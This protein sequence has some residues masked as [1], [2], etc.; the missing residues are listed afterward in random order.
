MTVLGY[1]A[2]F[3]AFT[4]LA[5]LVQHSD[6]GATTVTIAVAAFGGGGVVGNLVASRTSAGA[7]KPT[8]LTAMILMALTLAVLPYSAPIQARHPRRSER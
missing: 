4:Y 5:P 8:L 7:L 1:G 2:V 3:T 6:G